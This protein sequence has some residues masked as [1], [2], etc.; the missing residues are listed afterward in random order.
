MKL[1][2]HLLLQRGMGT[3]M[4]GKVI[5]EDFQKMFL[6]KEDLLSWQVVFPLTSC[7]GHI[8]SDWNLSS[9]LGT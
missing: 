5:R 9:H 1:Y 8:H 7:S 4:E 2:F 6:F 3:K